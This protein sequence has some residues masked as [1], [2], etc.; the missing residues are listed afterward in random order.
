MWLADLLHL[1]LLLLALR[2]VQASH[3]M[4]CSNFRWRC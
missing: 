1:L 4:R 3:A 2:S